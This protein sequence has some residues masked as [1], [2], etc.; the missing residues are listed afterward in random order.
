VK[1]LRL[2]ITKTAKLA[3]QTLGP[4][5]SHAA[6]LI[7]LF[8]VTGRGLLLVPGLPWS[9]FKHLLVGD[10]ESLLDSLRDVD[11]VRFQ[12]EAIDRLFTQVKSN[13]NT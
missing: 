12:P 3:P 5:F 4:Y 6:S 1:N 9:S 2:I 8:N 7:K 11:W 10:R 13:S